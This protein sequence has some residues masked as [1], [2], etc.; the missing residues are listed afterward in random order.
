[1]LYFSKVFTRKGDKGETDTTSGTRVSKGDALVE[2]EGT[3]DE[4][5]SFLGFAASMVEWDD[6]REDIAA[7]QEDI[8]T[9]GEDILAGGKKR[10]IT[11]ARVKWLEERVYVYKEEI[12][13]IKLFV[14]PGGSVESG[15]LHAVRTIARRLERTIVA[16][17]Q[18]KEISPHVLSYSNRLSSLLFMHALAANKRK[19]IEE[20]IWSINRES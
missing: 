7:I 13:K 19:G 5:N 20:R 12:G 14:V 3:T 15:I 17:S 16:A 10:A 1:M 4:L 2:V 6:I 18:L 8:F 9:L 11:E